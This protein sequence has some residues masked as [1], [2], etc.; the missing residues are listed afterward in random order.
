MTQDI[1]F[2]FGSKDRFFGVSQNS[3]NNKT[4]DIMYR[5]RTY[6]GQEKNEAEYA[7]RGAILYCTHGKI[8]RAHV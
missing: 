6:Y 7:L 3:E 4:L 8:G 5:Y 2:L 1:E